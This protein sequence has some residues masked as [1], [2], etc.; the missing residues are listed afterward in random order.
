MFH[1]ALI[2]RSLIITCFHI[3]HSEIFSRGVDYYIVRMNVNHRVHL[4]PCPVILANVPPRKRPESSS[5]CGTNES[6]F[7]L[8]TVLNQI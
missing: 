5:L 3:Y 1:C 4:E 2:Q 8:E 6:K 7:A